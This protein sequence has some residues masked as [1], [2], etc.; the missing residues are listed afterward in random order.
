MLYEINLSQMEFYARHGCYEL[1]RTVGNRFEVNLSLKV[2][3]GSAAADDDV[4]QTVN[5]L[6]VYRCV[7]RQMSVEQRTLERVA[8]NIIEALCS[9]FGAVRGVRCTVAKL[10]PPLG[11]K[12]GRVS[13]TLEKQR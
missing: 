4:A 8:T 10:A 9:E 3:M 13:V 12:V 11:G 6:E 2:D 7:A 5:Y 1:E